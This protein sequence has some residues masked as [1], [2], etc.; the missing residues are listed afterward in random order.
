MGNCGYVEIMDNSM[1]EVFGTQ[2]PAVTRKMG[3]IIQ[4]VLVE[5]MAIGIIFRNVDNNYSMGILGS[6]KENWLR[7]YQQ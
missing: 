2:T 1:F 5:F 4:T 3:F 6:S 7:Q